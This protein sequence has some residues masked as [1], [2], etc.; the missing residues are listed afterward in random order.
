MRKDAFQVLLRNAESKVA[1][2]DFQKRWRVAG[3]VM[4]TGNPS[5]RRWPRNHINSASFWGVADGIFQQVFKHLA[6]ALY[7]AFDRGNCLCLV[8]GLIPAL[9]MKREAISERLGDV[10]LCRADGLTRECGD[11][12]QTI[13][14]LK[15]ACLELS[16]LE[17]SIRQEL[18][19]P[20]RLLDHPEKLVLFRWGK[21]SVSAQQR[22]CIPIDHRQGCAQLMTN[23]GQKLDKQLLCIPE[24]GLWRGR[25]CEGWESLAWEHVHGFHYFPSCTA[26]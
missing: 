18:Q 9:Q 12:D 23:G 5:L 14:E 8:P 3:L 26:L 16:Y 20:A 11:V 19:A 1:H 15:N 13:I 21:L 10:P 25:C 24:R 4:L 2:A 17:Q 22:R 6:Q 7:I